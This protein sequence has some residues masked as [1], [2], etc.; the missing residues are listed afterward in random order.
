MGMKPTGKTLGES[1]VGMGGDCVVSNPH[2]VDEMAS[3]PG[4]VSA[5]KSSPMSTKLD[6]D[7]VSGPKQHG[8]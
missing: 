2:E 4:T 8:E 7:L 3:I 6:P 1:N 5:A